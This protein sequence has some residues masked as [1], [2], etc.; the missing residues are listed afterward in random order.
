MINWNILLPIL[1]VKIKTNKQ[2]QTTNKQQTNNKQ[3]TN[4]NKLFI[5]AFEIRVEYIKKYGYDK[6]KQQKAKKEI[7]K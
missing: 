6:V 1:N 3:T 2:Q 4:N 5:K 7:T